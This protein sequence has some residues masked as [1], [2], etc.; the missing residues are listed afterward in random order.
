V[1]KLD[2]ALTPDEVDA[3]L[4]SA[5]TAR[6]AT[7][8]RNGRPHV[9]PLWYV[10]LDGTMFVN[11]TRGN[12]SVRNIESNPAAAATVDDGESYEDLRGVVLRGPMEEAD[13]DPRLPQVLKAFSRKY[14]GRNPPPFTAWRNRFFLKLHPESITSWD[15][16]K[17]PDARARRDAER[18]A[19][20]P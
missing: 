4:A 7:V 3:F 10:W 8:G 5:R 9:V 15:F 18:K 2:I 17:I 12:R 6:V 16:R 14:Y 1:A 11:T 19:R 13:R 20:S